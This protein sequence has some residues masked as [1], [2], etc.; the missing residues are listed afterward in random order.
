MN[1]IVFAAYD[2]NTRFAI[3]TC[4]CLGFLGASLGG[5]LTRQ[6]GLYGI[7]VDQITSV[8]LVTAQGKSLHVDATHHSELWYAIRG[9]A[10]NF[11]VVTSAV[12]K[13]YPVPQA[14]NVAWEGAVTFSDDKLEALI[15]AIY[16]LVLQP[17]VQIDL[18][19]S[20]SGPPL[21]KTTITAIPFF[22]GNAS[23][24]EEAFASILKLG[25]IANGATEVP[26]NHWG[27]SGQSFCQKGMRK[28]AYGASLS[29]QGWDP[30]TW[31]AVYN[32]FN[33]FVRENPQAANS[34]VLAEYYPVQ[35]AVQ[36]GSNV[37]S[38]YPFRDVPLHVVVIPQYADSKLDGVA[39]AFGARVRDLLRSADGLVNNST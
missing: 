13:A 37:T 20:F 26:Y 27:D 14:Q 6:M 29:R 9:A 21:N 4:T 5:G 12:V 23:A 38:S 25:P 34:S 17:T 31:R 30:N 32:E 15:Q 36:I 8:N 3:P 39:N 35:K 22:L 1:D 7:L 10:P 2:N 11:G 24:A 16:D 33:K 18:L 28:P 19:F